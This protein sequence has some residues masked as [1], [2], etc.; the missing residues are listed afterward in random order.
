MNLRPLSKLRSFE[1]GLK[2]RGFVKSHKEGLMLH[3]LTV[4]QAT[5]TG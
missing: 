3:P 5:D 1:S 4:S 2:L